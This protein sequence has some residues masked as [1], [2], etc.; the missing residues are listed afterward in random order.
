[1]QVWIKAGGIGAF[2]F[3]QELLFVAAVENVVADVSPRL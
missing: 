3:L 1:M 2:K